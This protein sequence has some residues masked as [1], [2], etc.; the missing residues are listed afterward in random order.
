[1]QQAAVNSLIVYM[2]RFSLIKFSLIVDSKC[3]VYK[4]LKHCSLVKEKKNHMFTC[5]L[6]ARGIKEKSKQ[7]FRID[8]TLCSL[9]QANS[10]FG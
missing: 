1:M 7:S 5:A 8:S 4:Y 6:H 3:S 9:F 2:H 10:N